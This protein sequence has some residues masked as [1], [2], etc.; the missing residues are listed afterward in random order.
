M[1]SLFRADPPP[2]DD[3]RPLALP[4]GS[5]VPVRWVREPRA[6][7][8]RLLVTERGVRLTVPMRASERSAHAFL[9]EQRDW[10]ARILARRP[11][12]T[13]AATL[14]VNVTDSVPLR[15]E[16]VPLRW[17]TGRYARAELDGDALVLQLPARATAASARRAL[18]EFYLAQAR[19]DVGRWLPKYLPSLPAPPASLRLRPL[20]SL[21]G[22][23]GPRNDLSLD[24]S[25]V[26]GRPA[27][28]EYVLVHE[29]CHLHERNHSRRFW[30]HVE[31]H[32]PDWRD[33][34]TYLHGE[35]LALKAQLR[36]LIA[37]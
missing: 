33:E 24:L 3:I 9:L 34:R 36:G 18:K 28:F 7:R 17:T 22:S 27:A 37:P 31:V 29:L 15:G 19:G 10:L 26:L 1:F 21:W 14:E 13:V 11:P 23:L 25:L 5:E 30:R 4:D 2:A 20:A 8:L 12:P 35:G 6:R 32:W 16:T